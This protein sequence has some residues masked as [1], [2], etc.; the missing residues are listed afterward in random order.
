MSNSGIS[1][2]TLHTLLYTLIGYPSNDNG[3]IVRR[4]RIAQSA[5]GTRHTLPHLQFVVRKMQKNEREANNQENTPDKT[6]HH[7]Q[8]DLSA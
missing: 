7:R 6:S 5:I 3:I 4:I 8:Q 1:V 2:P